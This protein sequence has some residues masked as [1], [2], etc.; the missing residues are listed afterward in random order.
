MN[1]NTTQRSWGRA[2][3]L[4]A[5]RCHVTQ[6]PAEQNSGGSHRIYLED[7]RPRG[8]WIIALLF[9]FPK[10]STVDICCHIISQVKV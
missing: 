5:G 8:A 1:Q 2:L 7:V 9:C 4:M 3:W 6:P 10:P